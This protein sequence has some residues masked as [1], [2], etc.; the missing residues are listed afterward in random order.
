MKSIFSHHLS[1]PIRKPHVLISVATL[2]IRFFELKIQNHP[3]VTQKSTFYP[4]L[5]L[6]DAKVVRDA[7][8]EQRKSPF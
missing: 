6:P 3:T 8:M 4:L 2:L 5:P 1:C 7:N